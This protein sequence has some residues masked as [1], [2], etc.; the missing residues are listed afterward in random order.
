MLR[1]DKELIVASHIR[2]VRAW[3]VQHPLKNKDD[4][5]FIFMEPQSG[6]IM[7][8]I[9]K[10]DFNKDDKEWKYHN[11]DL[12]IIIGFYSEIPLEKELK[13]TYQSVVLEFITTQPEKAKLLVS[14]G[15]Y[16][17]KDV[18]RKMGIKKESDWAL[19]EE[20]V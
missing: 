3:M 1:L 15:C 16:W 9:H 7:G 12:D 5:Y 13:K 2:W 20:M 11:Y 19:L 8:R 10:K 18:L 14:Y 6:D 17:L 4:R